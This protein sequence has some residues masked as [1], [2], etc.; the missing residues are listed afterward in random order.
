MKR[1]FASDNNSGIHPDILQA[2]D[3]ANEGHAVGY[4]GD[5]FAVTAINRFNQKFGDQVEVF[6]VFNGTGANVLGLSTLAHSFNMV[7]F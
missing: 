5:K 6:F 2:I 1:G 4:G 7:T 3:S